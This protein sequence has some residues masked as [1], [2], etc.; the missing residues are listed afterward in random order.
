MLRLSAEL[1]GR[2]AA[3]RSEA[4]QHMTIALA[5]VDCKDLWRVLVTLFGSNR[6]EDPFQFLDGA[7]VIKCPLNLT[8]TENDDDT[9]VASEAASTQSKPHLPPRPPRR[10]Q[11]PSNPITSSGQI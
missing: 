4:F 7:P 8:D 6:E 10:N 11:S 5:G 1:E 3:L 9:S 2:A